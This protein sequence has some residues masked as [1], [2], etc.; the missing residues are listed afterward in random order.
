MEEEEENI[1]EQEEP[2]VSWHVTFREQRQLIIELWDVCYVSII[3]RTQFYLLFSGD[4]ADQIYMEVELRRLTW[5][6]KHLAELGNAS[7]AH[8]GDES[9]ISLSS[10]FFLSLL[11]LPSLLEQAFPLISL[12]S[13]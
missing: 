12:S 8:F 13:K 1:N 9:T 3:H 11:L 7:P 6:Q 4:P 10:R 2:Q 5:L